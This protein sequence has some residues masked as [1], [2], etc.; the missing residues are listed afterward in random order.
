MSAKPY[1]CGRTCICQRLSFAKLRMSP[2]KYSSVKVSRSKLY[3]SMRFSI[4]IPPR[5][6]L[7][8]TALHRRLH[9]GLCA[10]LLLHRV[11]APC[12]GSR[13]MGRCACDE[14]VRL[15]EAEGRAAKRSQEP[16]RTRRAGARAEKSADS[17]LR[18]KAVAMRNVIVSSWTTPCRGSAHALA[19]LVFPTRSLSQPLTEHERGFLM[20]SNRDGLRCRRRRHNDAQR[21]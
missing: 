21:K 14:V 19:S 1:C 10:L 17:N 16:A 13:P 15:A 3:T 18:C 6:P 12:G 20:P 11:T 7:P 8:G 5:E 4:M 9:R 2:C